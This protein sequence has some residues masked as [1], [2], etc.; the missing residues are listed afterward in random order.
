MTK[1]K[2]QQPRAPLADDDFARAEL[3]AA[4]LEARCG[5]VLDASLAPGDGSARRG[6]RGATPAH[7]AGLLQPRIPVHD[8]AVPGTD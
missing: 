7:R 5:R 8:D 3:E 2:N 1:M 4:R 6:D